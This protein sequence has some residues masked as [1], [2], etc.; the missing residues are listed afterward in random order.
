MVVGRFTSNTP[1]Q[2][3][4]GTNAAQS[5]IAEGFNSTSTRDKN[6]WGF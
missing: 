6:K 3:Q 5:S 4:T 1:G 2:A